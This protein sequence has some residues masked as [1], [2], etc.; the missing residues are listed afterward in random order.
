MVFLIMRE[1]QVHKQ[2]TLQL[3]TH[4]LRSTLRNNKASSHW[5]MLLISE[6]N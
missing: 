3:R 5:E 6:N 4:E 2:C 1:Q